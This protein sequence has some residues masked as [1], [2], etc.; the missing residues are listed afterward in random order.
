DRFYF[1]SLYTR[2]Y[3]GILFEFATEGPGFID[4]EEPYETLGEL[5]A[6][7]PKF[8]NRRDYI[9]SL[10]RP[11]DTIRSTRVFEKEYFD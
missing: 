10:V 5:L 6:L 4:D 3:P 9:E 11:I 1:K 8:R 2:L 7:P